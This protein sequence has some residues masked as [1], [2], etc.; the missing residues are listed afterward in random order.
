MAMFRPI[1]MYPFTGAENHRDKGGHRDKAPLFGFAT[2][3]SSLKQ[4]EKSFS[5]WNVEAKSL[6]SLEARTSDRSESETARGT[7]LAPC[8]CCFV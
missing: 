3:W 4:K 6:V 7:E 5:Q 8:G 2:D 1:L